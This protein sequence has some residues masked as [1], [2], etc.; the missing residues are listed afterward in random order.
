MNIKFP[1]CA[2]LMGLYSF[3]VIASDTFTGQWEGAV[4][5]DSTLTLR[6]NQQGSK[7]T[8]S[9][10]YITQKGNR[11]DCPAEGADN[12]QGTVN[13]NQAAIEF[14]SSYGGGTGHARLNINSDKMT[15]K[16]LQAPDKGEYYAPESYQLAKKENIAS[17]VTRKFTTEKF[18][19]TLSNKCGDFTSPC[20]KMFYLG[21]RKA[22]NSVITLNGTSLL[23]DK[24]EVIGSQYN[25][26]GVKYIVQYDPLRLIVKH[27]NKILVNETGAW[28]K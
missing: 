9:Y 19:V 17:S 11:I 1:A 7:L 14:T 23:N 12:L 13:N 15:W 16:M 20:N 24:G 22:D 28:V 4:Q 5:S 26:S 2:F 18:D 27:D 21:I 8:G 10:C 6:L 3:S 25:N